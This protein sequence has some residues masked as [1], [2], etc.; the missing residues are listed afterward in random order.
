MA[1]TMSPPVGGMSHTGSFARRASTS[2]ENRTN[3]NVIATSAA[4]TPSRAKAG[5]SR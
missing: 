2:P 4:T 3:W 1:P 5:N